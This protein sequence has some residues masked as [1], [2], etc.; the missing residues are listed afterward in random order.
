MGGGPAPGPARAGMDRPMPPV[1]RRG[2]VSR[3]GYG[4]RGSRR[5]PWLYRRRTRNRAARAVRRII[6]GG[7]PGSVRASGRPRRPRP[8]A[9]PKRIRTN[10]ASGRRA[11]S[12]GR[13][14]RRGGI[15]RR[16]SRGPADA[17]DRR[18]VKLQHDPRDPQ[19]DHQLDNRPHGE[20]AGHGDLHAG[21]HHHDRHEATPQGV[22]GVQDDRPVGGH[23]L[24]H[25]LIQIPLE[26]VLIFGGMLVGTE[27]LICC[28]A[29]GRPQW[30][31]VKG[32]TH[33]LADGKQEGGLRGTRGRETCRGRCGDRSCCATGPCGP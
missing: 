2:S 11:T 33:A 3:Q 1:R 26:V 9:P 7:V 32:R 29:R 19:A 24:V 16:G 31:L 27:G 23:N 14:S 17:G 30:S 18:G 8:V 20:R 10:R 12:G 5:L 21:P 28:C 22:A 13:R 4:R 25:D 15:S 6:A